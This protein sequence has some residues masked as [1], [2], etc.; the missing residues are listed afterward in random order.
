[1][2]GKIFVAFEGIDG[3][4]KIRRHEERQ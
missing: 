1:M 3:M 4:I 2:K